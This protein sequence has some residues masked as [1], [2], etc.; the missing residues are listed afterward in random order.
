MRFRKSLTLMQNFRLSQEGLNGS[1]LPWLG[2]ASEN[3]EA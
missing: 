2:D 3:L 1:W